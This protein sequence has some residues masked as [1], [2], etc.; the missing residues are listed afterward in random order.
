MKW[1]QV[2]T[3]TG[4]E[5]YELR[6]KDKKLLTLEFHPATNSSRIEYAAEKRVFLIRKEGFFNN[7]MVLCNEYGVRLGQLVHEKRESYIELNDKR[8][9]YLIRNNPRPELVIY[10]ESKEKPLV[11]CGMDLNNE[12]ISLAITEKKVLPNS[13]RSSLLLALS[14]YISLPVAREHAVEY[15]L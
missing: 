2:S 5:T 15:A 11:V 12:N 1:E 9:T 6:Q 14:W 3:T 13:L 8:F 4:R 10:K 7:K